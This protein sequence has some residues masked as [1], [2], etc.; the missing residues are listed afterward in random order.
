MVNSLRFDPPEGL[1]LESGNKG[2][3][4]SRLEPT[5]DNV[6]IDKLNTGRNSERENG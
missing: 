4:S 3:W 1:R 2:R 5:S 6:E